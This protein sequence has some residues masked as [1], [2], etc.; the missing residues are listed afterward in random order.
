MREYEKIAL[1]IPFLIHY[2]DS[3]SAVTHMMTMTKGLRARGH[4]VAAASNRE[5]LLDPQQV[6]RLIASLA[7]YGRAQVARAE[8]VEILGAREYGTVY[9]LS[10]LWSR[11]GLGELFRDPAARRR[12]EFDVEAG[13]RAI[14][15]SRVIDPCSERATIR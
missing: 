14:V 5:D 6:D 15:L 9:V 11:L 3:G 13:V 1:R 2:L 4:D 10:H 8:D 12:A 7:P